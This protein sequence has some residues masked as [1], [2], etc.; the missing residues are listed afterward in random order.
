ME[1]NIIN[2]GNSKGIIIPAKLLKMIGLGTVVN[3]DIEDGKLVISPSHKPR[4]GWGEI[5]RNEV[6]KNGQSHS[7]APDFFEDQN[8]D[9]TW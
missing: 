6:E 5:I 3:V 8:D 1:T 4:E 7:L 2:V 9:W